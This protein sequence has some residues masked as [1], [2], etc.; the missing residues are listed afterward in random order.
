VPFYGVKNQDQVYI[1]PEIEDRY[2]GVTTERYFYLNIEK[3]SL[4]DPTYLAVY[5]DG[6]KQ[7]LATDTD[8]DFVIQEVTDGYYRL[9]FLTHGEDPF[10]YTF[11]VVDGNWTFT[12]TDNF[13]VDFVYSDAA[14]EASVN[15]LNNLQAMIDNKIVASINTDPVTLES[16]L[17]LESP[18]TLE[19][20][21]NSEKYQQFFGKYP[22]LYPGKDSQG[23]F[24]YFIDFKRNKWRYC[25]EQ[26]L[27]RLMHITASTFPRG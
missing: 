14:K 10:K 13:V 11:S 25:F 4:P 19:F 24:K 15:M 6:V 3:G 22:Y 27:K 21:A 12:V 1:T 17:V 2:N 26:P 9:S 5:K 20:P 7:R 8:G 23:H 16:Y 18:Y